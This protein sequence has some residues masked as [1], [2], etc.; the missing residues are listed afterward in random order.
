[1]DSQLSQSIQH[2][3]DAL[4]GAARQ[5]WEA[6]CRRRGHTGYA[7]S[8][9]S[10]ED[11]AAALGFELYDPEL[12]HD[13][14]KHELPIPPR[15][16]LETA[17]G[18]RKG[19]DT[20]EDSG[21]GG[22][23]HMEIEGGEYLMK[24][25]K[26]DGLGMRTKTFFGMNRKKSIL[27]AQ[28]ELD[29]NYSTSS[30]EN[31]DIGD[32][33]H[34]GHNLANALFGMT[35]FA[36]TI[37]SPV[38]G[39]EQALRPKRNGLQI[40]Q[41]PAF[42][43]KN[44]RSATN[45]FGLVPDYKAGV[46]E[47][48]AAKAGKAE[49]SQQLKAPIA[50]YKSADQ[51][52]LLLPERRAYSEALNSS[53]TVP[54]S[55]YGQRAKE[56]ALPSIVTNDYMDNISEQRE[57]ERSTDQSGRNF[58]L[59]ALST[60]QGVPQGSIR[61]PPR[62]FY[63][64]VKKSGPSQKL[65]ETRSNCSL[66]NEKNTT[67]DAR[68]DNKA[69]A[70]GQF[71]SL[72]HPKNMSE[73]RSISSL[74]QDYNARKG[75]DDDNKTPT[76]S[77]FTTNRRHSYSD[78]EDDDNKS[79]YGKSNSCLTLD[80]QSGVI[81][82]ASRAPGVGA[83]VSGIEVDQHERA[84]AR[85]NAL[86]ALTG[87]P[88]DSDRFEQRTASVA[89]SK[90]LPRGPSVDRVFDPRLM[91]K[92]SPVIFEHKAA[93]RENI[94]EQSPPNHTHTVTAKPVKS[95]EEL[96]EKRAPAE[97]AFQH[98]LWRAPGHKFADEEASW[99]KPRILSDPFITTEAAS[100]AHMNCPLSSSPP[101]TARKIPE[102]PP[103]SRVQTVRAA[104]VKSQEEL[105]GERGSAEAASR[106]TLWRASGHYIV[107]QEAGCPRDWKIS[108]PD[109][110]VDKAS[111]SH[112]DGA[113]DRA[114]PITARGTEEQ[115]CSIHAQTISAGSLEELKEERASAKAA[116]RRVL[117]RASG[118]T[119]VDDESSLS[120]QQKISDGVDPIETPS[121]A[122]KDRPLS[123]PPPPTVRKVP[124][125]LQEHGDPFVFPPRDDSL[126]SPRLVRGAGLN[127]Q[128]LKPPAENNTKA[129]ASELYPKFGTIVPYWTRH[130]V[131]KTGARRA[132]K[133]AKGP[134]ADGNEDDTG[135]E[136][137][138]E[139]EEEEEE[140][141][142]DEQ[143][144]ERAPGI[145]QL[146]GGVTAINTRT[147]R[148]STFGPE[149]FI[150]TIHSQPVFDGR[151]QGGA[152][153][154][155]HVSK[156]TEPGS[157]TGGNRSNVMNDRN[158]KSRGGSESSG[159]GQHTPDTSSEAIFKGRK[160][161]KGAGDEA[162][163]FPRPIPDS[164]PVTA[165]YQGHIDGNE[166]SPPFGDTP[167]SSPRMI[168]A[169]HSHAQSPEPSGTRGRTSERVTSDRARNVA[170]KP[171]E[172]KQSSEDQW[173]VLKRPT[174]VTKASHESVG[175]TSGVRDRFQQLQDRADSPLLVTK[176]RRGGSSQS[177][178]G[179]RDESTSSIGSLRG[180][181]NPALDRVQNDLMA[182]RRGVSGQQRSAHTRNISGT[183]LT[184]DHRSTRF[185][186]AGGGNEA[187]RPLP[188]S[189]TLDGAAVPKAS[190]H[191]NQL[192]GERKEEKAPAIN[193]ALAAA[194]SVAQA[195]EK[196]KLQEKRKEEERKK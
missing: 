119:F 171:G 73:T 162:A 56:N 87:A 126:T 53:V 34:G 9:E 132:R 14:W 170:S 191:S 144:G 136:N 5:K 166:S 155:L 4:A 183:V 96:K 114:P 97:N 66:R 62:R 35:S 3:E 90:I 127:L 95:L 125:S 60:E 152:T 175:S 168:T 140:E 167:H 36:T 19:V 180:P 23:Y 115:H 94:Q 153:A 189:S 188:R 179:R 1:M 43:P 193:S 33:K 49:R 12:A 50:D 92:P 113:L 130:E 67:H 116:S 185:G 98:V 146:V 7:S 75:A 58:S 143:E 77:H 169:L 149:D 39:M 69:P 184:G 22:D 47:K 55:M 46:K 29:S 57:P 172:Q 195:A 64:S 182:G 187:A 79:T 93:Y 110:L 68:G 27:P 121:E 133:F 156:A 85:H 123:P 63:G 11:G 10:P 124:F 134:A 72:S 157:I 89:Y 103:P 112:M 181:V 165:I 101:L 104:S 51:R 40:P 120:K 177:R 122:H 42:R 45:L 145:G 164:R 2:R 20:D 139:K 178:R 109:G 173:Q 83:M 135:N 82:A 28:E 6:E 159:E 80:E 192:S 26:G 99:D 86:A 15:V 71:M 91:T 38:P 186:G 129:D 107:D 108:D 117:W 48:N 44:K 154:D 176:H 41:I 37:A 16:L 81:S 70:R 30:S 84:E 160:P 147:S 148:H 100:E 54:P 74:Y 105:K 150:H 158:A 161:N 88:Q 151:I 118:H 142:K 131:L 18:S 24:P 76:A 8:L 31:D 32:D 163:P 52:S 59:A 174:D 196:K 25:K 128:N 106:R 13:D 190:A 141:G 138:N 17:T 61:G 194:R 78:D 111:K 21:D 65:L 137:E 102:L